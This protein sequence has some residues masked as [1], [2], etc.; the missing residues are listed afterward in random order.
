LAEVENWYSSHISP[1]DNY[2]NLF[3]IYKNN[4]NLL[5][6]RW[7]SVNSLNQKFYKMFNSSSIQ[8]RVLANWRQLKFTREAWRC[9]LLASRNQNTLYKRFLSE[10][11]L[12]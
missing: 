2:F 1:M 11:G 10:E 3:T 5:N 6:N 12:V 4:Q 8:Q 7:V 9:K